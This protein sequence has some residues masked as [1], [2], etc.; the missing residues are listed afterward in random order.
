V[1]CWRAAGTWLE[2]GVHS[3]VVGIT[4]ARR[5]GLGRAPADARPAHARPAHARPAH[6]RPDTRL[7]A[8]TKRKP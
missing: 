1:V 5:D 6:A 8:N 2:R 3:L 4:G 7:T